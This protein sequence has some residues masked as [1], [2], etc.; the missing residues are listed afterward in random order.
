MKRISKSPKINFLGDSKKNHI[1]TLV[2]SHQH[3]LICS[4]EECDITA[5]SK[6]SKK[7]LEDYKNSSNPKKLEIL[8]DILKIPIY[9]I[10]HLKHNISWHEIV[11]KKDYETFQKFINL[12]EK[13]YNQ[14]HKVSDYSKHM[15]VNSRK[16]M[17]ICKLHSG[18]SCK[19]LIENR[20][21]KESHE[22]LQNSSDALKKI[23]ADL[24]FS[25]QF[26]FSKF[27]KKH[28]KVSPQLFRE[29]SA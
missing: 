12:L 21:V 10:K 23:A 27:F 2:L 14:L 13:E 8:S 7:P 24:G 5:F 1:Y 15:G 9:K 29:Q 26:Q 6:L 17:L 19:D 18:E 25:D 11:N 3:L 4:V 16:L 22:R 20:I 28:N